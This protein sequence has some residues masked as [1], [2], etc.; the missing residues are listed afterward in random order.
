VRHRF[1]AVPV[2]LVLTLA[3]PSFANA[4]TVLRPEAG[5]AVRAQ[6]VRS[7]PRATS[8]VA[9][10][11][12]G[13]GREE[14]EE[15]FRELKRPRT[16]TRRL[17]GRERFADR[18]LT[19]DPQ[20]AQVVTSYAGLPQYYSVPYDAAIAVSP[21]QVLVMTNNQFAVY[22]KAT[23]AKRSSGLY[24]DFF[25]NA[26][27]GGYDPKCYYD[28]AAGR[29]VM[30]ALEW[31]TNPNRAQ[32]DLAVSQTADASGAWYKYLYDAT[33]NGATPT[34]TWSDF[35]GLGYDDNNVYLAT[36]QF[37]FSGYFQ[38]SKLR[39]WS[40]QQL[41][42][43]G[44]AS[45]VD[46]GPIRNADGSHAFAIKPA[47]AL[48][49]TTTGRMF[50]T[51]PSGGSS[52]STWTVSGAFPALSLSAA[53]TVPIGAY[54]VG[55]DARQPGSSYRIDTGDCRTQ[56][57]VWRDGHTYTAF[58]EKKGSG[59]SAVTAV[60]YLDVT[61]AGA[62]VRDVTYSASGIWLY[63]PAVSADAAGNVAMVFERSSGSEYVSA[64]QTRLPAG[65][66]FESSQRLSAGVA[67]NTRG[68]WGDYNGVANDASDSSR[69]WVFGGYGI[70]GNKW[71]TWLASLK[72]A[73][74]GAAPAMLALSDE[75]ADA[76]APAEVTP[77]AIALSVTRASNGA[78]DFAFELP[79]AGPVR[80]GLFDLS[81]RRLTTLADGAFEAGRHEV[82][83]NRVAADGRH[84]PAGVYWARIESDGE[85]AVR[86]VT[87]VD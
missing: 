77:A 27:G 67:A 1:S 80:L 82:A 64:Y 85:S 55:P 43:G 30:M 29:F 46:F 69:V 4:P 53:R 37:N 5:P 6:L 79:H 15:R 72:P 19:V 23:G 40:K 56:D 84:T 49:A 51:R 39:V 13:I 68:R 36:N 33:L 54:A 60:R 48:S 65:G 25:G 58:T 70:A 11:E 26:A 50:A 47:R 87:L 83:W 12:V 18:N 41:Y 44:T 32:I 42:A 35:P 22:D 59:S 17:G 16:E 74:S 24:I 86:R 38:F 14:G 81:G 8:L 57:V 78:I 73:T 45:Y 31:S 28:R 66:A 2:L 76:A 20:A 62:A 21:S 7:D 61:D 10:N 71:A 52:V 3:S 9:P 75:S 34:G 63:Y